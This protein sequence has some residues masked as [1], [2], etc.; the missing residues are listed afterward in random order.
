MATIDEIVDRLEAEGDVLDR[1]EFRGDRRVVV[2]AERLSAVMRR[3]RVEHGFDMLVD[4]T[5]VDYLR[6]E[7]ARDRF[8]LVYALSS[9]SEN[10]RLWV[11]VFLNEPDLEVDSLVPLWASA[12]WMEREVYDM[13]GI[14]FRGHRDLRRIL[15]PEAFEGHP[16]RKDYPL[17]GLGERHHFEVLRRGES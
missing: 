8:G 16:L 2:A 11:R 15:L 7:G 3:L 6:Y 9:T 13:F 5:C 4:L 14:V 17:Q 12:D 1:S 10:R